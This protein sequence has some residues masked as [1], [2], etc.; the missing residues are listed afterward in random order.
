MGRRL[1]PRSRGRSPDDAELPLA[2]PRRGDRALRGRS[3]GPG[4]DADTEQ[5]LP[6]GVQ[7]FAIAPLGETVVWI[8]SQRTLVIGDAIIGVSGG[9]LRVCPDS[10]LDYGPDPVTPAELREYLRPLL[11]LPVERVLVAHGEPVLERGH[12]ALEQALERDVAFRRA[13]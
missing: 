10:W 7:T 2:Q 13:S 8:T 12:A 11:E 5:I 9:G 6:G 4:V 1:L 3:Y